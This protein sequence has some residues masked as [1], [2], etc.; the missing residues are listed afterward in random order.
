MQQSEADLRG[1]VRCDKKSHAQK[2][3][4]DGNGQNRQ[5]GKQLVSRDLPQTVTQGVF[6]FR[7]KHLANTPHPRCREQCD[8]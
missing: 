7:Q 6:S 3:Q 1:S 4:R 8:H 2:G 5:E